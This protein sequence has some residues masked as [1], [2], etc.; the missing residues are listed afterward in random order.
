MQALPT[1]AYVPTNSLALAEAERAFEEQ[2]ATRTA[3]STVW[4][5]ALW[6]LLKVCDPYACH[7]R[8]SS[9]AFSLHV[10]VDTEPL[11]WHASPCLLAVPHACELQDSQ[12][13][14]T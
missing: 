1:V 4:W 11:R 10:F 12:L 3:T 8:L 9:L 13:A 6:V 2:L 7:G 14:A 5:F